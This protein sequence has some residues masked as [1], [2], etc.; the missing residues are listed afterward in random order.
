[1]LVSQ[2]TSELYKRWF[3]ETFG[4]GLIITVHGDL[5][6]HDLILLVTPLLPPDGMDMNVGGS[7]FT[8]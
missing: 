8:L 1:M 5:D 4:Y 7:V 2:G 3:S 6:I